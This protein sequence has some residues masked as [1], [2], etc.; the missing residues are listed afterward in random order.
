MSFTSKL[1]GAGS[2]AWLERT[3]DRS[4]IDIE[5]VWSGVQISPGPSLNV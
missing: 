2:S 5:T 3:A 4:R 1:E